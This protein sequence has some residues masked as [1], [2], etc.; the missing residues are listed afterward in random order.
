[1]NY[2]QIGNE[3]DEI[4]NS[5][6]AMSISEMEDTLDRLDELNEILET[7]A[8]SDTSDDDTEYQD[9]AEMLEDAKTTIESEIDSA[10]DFETEDDY[11]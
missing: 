6:G 10:S 1:M 11:Y 7:L 5:V 3:V 4:L 8:E 9:I 2:E